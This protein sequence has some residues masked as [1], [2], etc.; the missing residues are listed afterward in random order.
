MLAE[1]ERN[2]SLRRAEQ[3]RFELPDYTCPWETWEGR[4]FSATEHNCHW[5]YYSYFSAFSPPG[6][7][8]FP[9]QLLAVHQEMKYR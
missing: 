7:K 8:P 9:S 3:E 2:L 5:V 4:H 1:V 6:E